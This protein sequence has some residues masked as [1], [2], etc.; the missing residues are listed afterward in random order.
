MEEHDCYTHGHLLITSSLLSTMDIYKYITQEKRGISNEREALQEALLKWQREG[1][2]NG[3]VPYSS[4]IV[5]QPNLADLTVFAVL[6]SC[7]GMPIHDELIR[8][9]GRS[10]S[11]TTLQEQ[12]LDPL[13]QWYQRIET[14]LYS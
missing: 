8:N 9:K 11:P 10:S 13:K 1:L 12:D 3:L 2:Q 14:L 5:N 7:Q 6:H 4:G